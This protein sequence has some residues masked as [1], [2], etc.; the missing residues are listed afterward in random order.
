[1]FTPLRIAFNVSLWNPSQSEW[2]FAGKCIQPEERKR[3]SEFHYKNDAKLSLIGRLLL[4]YVITMSS[5][6]DWIDLCLVRDS[7]SKPMLAQHHNSHVS[8]NASHQGDYVV[9]VTDFVNVGVDVMDG[10]ERHG[11]PEKFFSL[12]KR[13]FTN[14]EWK[15]IRSSGSSSIQMESFYRHWCLKE[16]FVKAIGTGIAYSLLSLNFVTKTPL[17]STNIVTDTILY[18]KRQVG[19]N[20]SF[21]ESLLGDNHIVA[22][23][24]NTSEKLGSP[25]F[26]EIEFNEIKSKAKPLPT[27]YTEF[28]QIDKSFNESFHNPYKQ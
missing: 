14:D 12:M 27:D 16:S 20:W 26:K 5:G 24:R 22:V 28:E 2:I 17:V 13:H 3:I 9:A 21:E 25:L 4:R 23:A 18:E 10:K 11:D 1:M 19:L 15:E 6:I 8:F 7:K